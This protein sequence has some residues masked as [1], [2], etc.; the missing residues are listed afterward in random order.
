M[1]I[2]F[3]KAWLCPFLWK[4]WK[5]GKNDQLKNQRNLYGQGELPLE[6]HVTIFL[7]PHSNEIWYNTSSAQINC[8][9]VC[10]KRLFCKVLF[11]IKF[12]PELL[13]FFTR[14]IPWKVEGWWELL[15]FLRWTDQVA[16]PT[17]L[18]HLY[19]SGSGNDY[20]FS[21][22]H[23]REANL[24]PEITSN[25]W[26][27]LV[28]NGLVHYYSPFISR[29]GWSEIT[30]HLKV[31][32]CKWKHLGFRFYKLFCTLHRIILRPVLDRTKAY[33]EVVKRAVH[34]FPRG[35]G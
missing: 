35:L 5:Q 24:L 11:Y 25:R 19:S 21:G 28:G 31:I 15:K 20:A 9:W 2:S 23:F 32:S 13:H 34:W 29:K 17:L 4:L 10:I 1:E 16:V 12:P 26:W 18:H 30:T 7:L 3:S 14:G 27:N 8:A 33:L 6:Y 22:S